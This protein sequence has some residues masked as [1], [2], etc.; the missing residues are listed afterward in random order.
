MKIFLM[1]CIAAMVSAGVYGTI[2]LAQ[3][4]HQGT[5][6]QY[7]KEDSPIVNS[8]T[9]INNNVSN[10]LKIH[11]VKNETKKEENVSKPVINLSDLKMEY[12]SRGEP[13]YLPELETAL[14]DSAK[15]VAD[16]LVVAS[17]E[18]VAEIKVVPVVEERKFSSKLFS[19][20]RPRPIVKEV[21][22]AQTDSVKKETD[23]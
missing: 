22:I 15:Q 5:F 21:T 4:I 3:D 20:S 14:T 10:R 1:T 19:R 11:T 18:G 13:I 12:F 8:L 17:T 9:T 7:E 16:S 2:D 23:N 6:I